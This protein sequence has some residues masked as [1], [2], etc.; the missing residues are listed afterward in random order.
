[1][2]MLFS[3]FRGGV[4]PDGFKELSAG[5]PISVLPVPEQLFVPLRQHAG[6]DAIAIVKAGDKVLKGQLIANPG[7]GLS[8]PVH[9]PSSGIIRAIQPITAA[10]PSGMKANAVII[11]CD[12]DDLSL[13][14][15]LLANPFDLS[16]ALVSQKIAAAGIV[17]MGGASFPAAVK[18]ASAVNRQ[19]ET[20][21]INGGECEPYLTADDRLMCERADKIVLGARLIRHV[22]GA[23]II[24]VVV[25][26]NK[27]EAI[28][29]LQRATKG[30]GYINVVVV[31]TRYPM[32]SAK[33]MIQAATGYEVPAGGRSSDV[34]VL[35]HNVA[36]A[37]AIAEALSQDKPLISRIVTVSGGAI[38]KPQNVEA[39]IGTPARVLINH[40]GGTLETPARLLLGG[41]MMGHIMPNDEVP[42]I[43][44]VAGIL[45]LQQTEVSQRKASPCIRC[46][47]CVSACPMGLVPLEMANHARHQ[48]FEGA[49]D[50]G[51]TDC[52]LCGSCAYVCPSHIPLVHYFQYAKGMISAKRT[53]E[54]HQDF[55]RKLAEARR[56]RMEKEEAEKAA[57]KAARAAKRRQPK[58]AAPA[59]TPTAT[60]D[61]E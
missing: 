14:P 29:A 41:P 44:G 60:T 8:A 40:C 28:A 36:T 34:G 52:I 18:L 59:A 5:Q 31:P 4:H 22:V 23:N 21:L 13:E 1:M 17:G 54:K 6:S 32:G 37:Y 24:A 3:P 46:S 12:G 33:Q 50:Y 47:R 15:Q 43:K 45:A 20:V 11:D 2:T 7:N 10:H 56:H 39:P 57:A 26:D 49:N 58:D 53:H 61:A 16:P 48:D 38:A 35:M 55:T 42:L 25:E 51:L 9:A 27:P 30:F 19:I